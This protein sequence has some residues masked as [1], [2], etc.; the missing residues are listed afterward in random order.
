[1]AEPHLWTV[2]VPETLWVWVIQSAVRG[3]P[4]AP[5]PQA[6]TTSYACDQPTTTTNSRAGWAKPAPGR[7]V[8]RSGQATGIC[9][10]QRPAGYPKHRVP[11]NLL[12]LCASSTRFAVLARRILGDAWSSK[13]ACRALALSILPG[14]NIQAVRTADP[15]TRSKATGW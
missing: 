5:A 4:C 6:L 9:E 8:E 11:I 13:P 14:S 3:L 12:A 7:L 10:P 1:M 15:I 2:G